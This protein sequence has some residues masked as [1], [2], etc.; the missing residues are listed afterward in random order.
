MSSFKSNHYVQ[1]QVQGE[2]K[3]NSPKILELIPPRCVPSFKSLSQ[4]FADICKCPISSQTIKHRYKY[5]SNQKILL[6]T[7]AC[8]DPLKVYTNFQVSRTSLS[9]KNNKPEQQ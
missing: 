7:N 5:K 9:K 1:V 4:V 8:M 6:T 3:K 2:Q